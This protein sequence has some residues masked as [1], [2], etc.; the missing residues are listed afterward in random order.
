MMVKDRLP[1]VSLQIDQT[2]IEWVSQYMYLGVI[3][4]SQLKFDK[5]VTYLRQRASARFS[6][7]KHMTSL[8]E[9][10]NL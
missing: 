4:D 7:M 9:G 1:A 2:P 8:Q 5:E 3:I 6:T 10:A